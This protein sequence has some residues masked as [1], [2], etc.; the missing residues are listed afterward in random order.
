MA[1]RAGIPKA[2]IARV[3]H[4]ISE[5]KNEVAD[6][7]ESAEVPAFAPKRDDKNPFDDS[8][9]IDLFMPLLRRVSC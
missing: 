9:L 4:A 2:Q 3:P 1:P 7:A 5:R 8:D 6:K